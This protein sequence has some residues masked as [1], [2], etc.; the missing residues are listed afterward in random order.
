[1]RGRRTKPPVRSCVGCRTVADREALE[2][3]A[4]VDGEVVHDPDGRLPGRG[5]WLHLSADC[6]DRARER[7]AFARA[8]RASVSIPPETLDLIATW[9]K[10]A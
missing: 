1:M 8:F 3:F 10:S 2:R 7:N 6:F 5:A 9:P 4:S